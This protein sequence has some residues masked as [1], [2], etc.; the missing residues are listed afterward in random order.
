MDDQYQVNKEVNA[1]GLQKQEQPKGPQPGTLPAPTDFYKELVKFAIYFAAFLLPPF[2]AL[3]D[4]SRSL[5]YFVAEYTHPF[6]GSSL[7]YT[8]DINLARLI[9][10]FLFVSLF[11]IYWFTRNF[12]RARKTVR[13]LIENHQDIRNC[14]S[15][16]FP[17]D[18]S[19]DKGN[20]IKQ[21]SRQLEQQRHHLRKIHEEMYDDKIQVRHNFI[22][23]RARYKVN[24][25]GDI[26]VSK[27]IILNSPEL[28]VHF[29]RFY[30]DGG[31][32]ATPLEDDIDMD[33]EVRA[34]GDNTTD[35]IAILLENEPTRKIFTVHFL[36][37]IQKGQTRSFMLGY[38]WQ[39]FFKELVDTGQTQY[40]WDTSSYSDDALSDFSVEW[41]FD[42]ELGDVRCEI[43]AKYEM[44]GMNL[45]REPS[46]RGS[47]WVYFGR[48]VA[49]G[50]VR[51]ALNFWR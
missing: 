13:V 50:N 46:P 14:K 37:T 39:G 16:A 51:L 17:I 22:S 44:Q 40:H 15:D 10:I 4:L 9:V 19:D 29:W 25:N 34:L 49:I 11:S 5:Q 8:I 23:F 31:S 32:H 43:P 21:L 20:Q 27:E 26:D 7:R 12:I 18:S 1:T 38:R 28:E 36:P 3:D 6:H 24:A 2:W 35:V 45:R 41:H 42:E 47:T 48:Q 33:L 30:A